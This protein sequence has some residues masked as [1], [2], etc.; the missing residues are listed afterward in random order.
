MKPILS[1]YTIYDRSE[2]AFW[3]LKNGSQEVLGF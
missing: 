1:K 3:G 2:N